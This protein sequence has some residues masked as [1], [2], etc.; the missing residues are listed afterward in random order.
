MGAHTG[1]LAAL[2]TAFCWAA[3]ALSFEA[4]G[5]R[6]GSL[7]VNI[8]R[9]VIGSVFLLVTTS[10]LRGMPFPT[11][12]T[13][14]AFLWLG[15]SGIVGF[16]FGDLCLFRAFVLVGPRI[17]TLMMSMVPPMAA[18]LGW[19]ILGETLSPR[20]MTGMGLTV[21]GIMWAILDRTPGSTQS[22][23][24][25]VGLLLALGG[26]LGQ[27]GGLVLSKFGMGDY[28]PFAATQIR[29]YWGLGA[30]AI[31]FTV[32]RRWRGMVDSLSDRPGVGFTAI[33]AFF[34]PFLGV[35]MSLLAVQHATA[36]V[37]ASIMATTPIVIIPAVIL[38]KK[39]KVGL[40]GVLGA[41]LAVAGVALLFT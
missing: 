1:E 5:K 31:I 19:M 14:H 9:L 15:L 12:A 16:A 18:V 38:I 35:S 30:F 33:G 22:K 21:G 34:G 27:A 8:I 13:P 2:T 6:I 10:I 26:A 20:D 37:A 17:S 7:N 24:S 28:D 41:I 4:A 23:V 11:D 25:P 36:G 29:L 3:S 39:E 40:G 32:T